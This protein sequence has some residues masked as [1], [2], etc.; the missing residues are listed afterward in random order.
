MAVETKEPSE[1]AD[2]QSST[3]EESDESFADENDDNEGAVSENTTTIA[4]PNTEGSDHDPVSNSVNG[5]RKIQ[6]SNSENEEQKTENEKAP[7]RFF[8]KLCPQ[9]FRFEQKNGNTLNIMD[10]SNFR[11]SC[12]LEHHIKTRHKPPPCD[13]CG[14]KFP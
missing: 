9:A 14:K 12:W 2:N 13:H 10:D 3:K 1:I 6:I 7:P 8:C 5:K 4:N 11:F